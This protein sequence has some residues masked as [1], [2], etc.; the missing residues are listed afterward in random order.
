MRK[1]GTTGAGTQRWQCVSCAK[2][3]IKKR[4]DQQQRAIA[5]LFPKWLT[6]NATLNDLAKHVGVSTQ[7]LIGRF[8]NYWHQ[9]C[10]A[11]SKHNVR[12]IVLDATGIEHNCVL[13]IML[14]AQTNAPIAWRPAVRETYASWKA[15][16]ERCPQ[17][18]RYAVCDGHPG[19][20]KAVRER[21]PGIFIQRCTAHVLREMRALLTHHPKLAAGI[22]LRILVAAMP[23]I[24]T[25]RQKRKWI[26]AFF[27]WRKKYGQ[28]L[29]EKTITF[30]RHWHYTHRRL[31]RAAT[32]LT[33]ALPHLFRYVSDWSVPNTSNQVEGGLNGPIKDLV[34][35]HR[36]L[37]VRR[38][39]ILATF[40]LKKRAEKSTRNFN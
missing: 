5:L 3:G 22:A 30:G 21:W 25:R 18:P 23:D 17:Q 20:L 38:R 12:T 11:I 4:P 33:R 36:G 14:D 28:F 35:K 40:Y 27:Y 8:K 13:L 1:Y 29:K 16:L 6:G 15:L 39:L 7:T 26:R 19:L 32:H 37:S 9:P 10:A 2:T 24:H 31:R 34:R